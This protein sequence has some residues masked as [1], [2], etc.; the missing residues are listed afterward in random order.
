MK[1]KGTQPAA[2]APSPVQLTFDYDCHDIKKADQRPLEAD[3]DFITGQ[4]RKA[5]QA[6]VEAAFEIGDRLEKAR[7]R[8]ANYKNGTFRAWVEERCGISK[9]SAYR[10]IDAARNIP[11]EYRPTV[12]RYIDASAL[13]VLSVDSCPE[14]ATEEAIRLAAE[15]GERITKKRAGELI[16]QF[17]PADDSA[18]P[19]PSISAEPTDSTAE[20]GRPRRLET[21]DKQ[22]ACLGMELRP[23]GKGVVS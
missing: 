23:N 20:P 8:L 19:P 12:G 22:A 6:V 15:E 1:R 2:R 16:R 3:A 13:Y 21:A 14:D 9:S 7:A 11:K 18:S 10:M 4:H 5:S 17:S